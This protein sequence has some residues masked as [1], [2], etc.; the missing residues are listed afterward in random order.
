[1]TM[2][3]VSLLGVWATPILG[4]EPLQHLWQQ[5]VHSRVTSPFTLILF[6]I[7]EL[8]NCHIHIIF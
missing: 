6:V 3:S 7:F 4:D 1:M 2:F 5:T 8:C